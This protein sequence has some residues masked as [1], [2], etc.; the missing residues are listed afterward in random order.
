M[1]DMSTPEF[2]IAQWRYPEY[3]DISELPNA[4]QSYI[5]PDTYV[6][7]RLNDLCISD[8]V[9]YEKSYHRIKPVNH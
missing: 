3:Y 5:H 7:T 2:S 4:G 1:K 9:D 6:S 8:F